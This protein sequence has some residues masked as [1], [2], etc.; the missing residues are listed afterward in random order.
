M[1][2]TRPGLTPELEAHRAGA[3]IWKA[4]AFEVSHFRALVEHVARLAY[5]NP[6][7]LLFFAARTRTT[8][9]RREERRYTLRSTEVTH[10]PAANSVTGSIFS[11]KRLGFW[12]RSSRRRGS[13]DTESSVRS[14]TF[15][16]ASF[17]TT[18]SSKRLCST[19]R[20]RFA[21]PARLHSCGARIQP[22]TFTC[23]G[24]R[25]LRI[26]YRSTLNTTS[27]TFDC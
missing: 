7:E 5:A 10:S 23:L 22:V 14:D 12:L 25:T 6:D 18:R 3:P 16:G 20:S 19:S 4:S 26:E 15:N 13:M 1:R 2:E 11:T 9:A 24:F 21:L 27:S 8:K 17:S